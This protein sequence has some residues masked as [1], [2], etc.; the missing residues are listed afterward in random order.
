MHL[1]F[2]KKIKEG[3]IMLEKGNKIKINL[4]QI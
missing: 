2:L 4:N 1:V 3:K